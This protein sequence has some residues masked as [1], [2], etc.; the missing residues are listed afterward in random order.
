MKLTFYGGAGTVTGSNYLLESGTTRILIDCGL[1]QGTSFCELSNFKPFAYE[2]KSVA[3]VFIT[4]AHIDHIG[5]LPQLHKHGFQGRII[6]SD[7][8]RDFAEALLVDTEHIMR[9][10][11]ARKKKEPIYDLKDIEETMKLWEGISY[12]H[13]VEIGPFVIELYDAGHVLG[14]AS[15]VVSAEGKKIVFSGDLGNVPSPF[16]RP[17]EYIS[18]VDYALVESTYGDRIHENLDSRKEILED[19]IEE[20]VKSRGVVMIP[21][22]ALERTQEMLFELN[23]LV[24]HGRIPKVPIFIDSPLAIKL[25]AAYQ[26][27]SSN[28]MYFSKEAIDLSRKGDAIFNFPGLHMTLSVE[29]S[30]EINEV[31]V[32][33][34]IIAGSGM[35]QG[36]RIMHHEQRYLSDPKSTILFVGYQAVGSLGRQILD[37]AKIVRVL[38]EDVAVHCKV[39]AIGG[40]SAHADQPQLLR[41]VEPMK[42]HVKK[43]FV[44]QGELE[45]ANALAEKIRDTLAVNAEVPVAESSV[46]L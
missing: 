4:H 13:K 35:S 8:S 16:I 19:L 38:G 15:V 26:K 41:W 12:H 23:E 33:K 9:E 46:M 40:Y 29:Q 45:S 14:S 42:E 7:P 22:F 3:A 11:A 32:P 18:N 43:I 44:V 21:A 17:T 20:T 1:F 34:V 31:P 39:R 25:T 30:K 28:P 2:P 24:E 10:E 5:R 36:G 37:G 6:S 27:Y